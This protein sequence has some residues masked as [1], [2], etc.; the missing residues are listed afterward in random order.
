M[1][2]RECQE[3]YTTA[4]CMQVFGAKLSLPVGGLKFIKKGDTS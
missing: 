4:G 2:L 1:T 3:R